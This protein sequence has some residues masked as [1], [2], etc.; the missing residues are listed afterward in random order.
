M[1]LVAW[2]CFVV[3]GETGAS[4]VYDVTSE[5]I[6]PD[7]EMSVSINVLRRGKAYTI[8]QAARLAR[9]SAPTVRNWLRGYA[10]QGHRME[11]VFGKAKSSRD[12]EPLQVSFL[13]L[14]EII[15]VA[16]Y[17]RRAPR[18]QARRSRTA[19][20]RASVRAAPMGQPGVPIR[21]P[22]IRSSRATHD[23]PVPTAGT[24]RR[25][26]SRWIST[27]STPFRS[28][29]RNHS[30]TSS[31]RRTTLLAI[32]RPDVVSQS[33]LTHGSARDARWSPGP[34]FR[35]RWFDAAGKRIR[36]SRRSLAP[37]RSIPTRSRPFCATWLRETLL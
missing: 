28:L 17:R 1:R 10:G 12:G 34:A 13:E 16:S 32:S 20:H 3:S 18:P 35:S 2:S 6:P 15:V 4:E 5:S 29:C 24:W 8:P 11:P 9:T 21:E 23:V 33:L 7:L 36:A 19:P 22:P 14:A 25:G 26:Y 37:L 30:Q 31:S 27:A